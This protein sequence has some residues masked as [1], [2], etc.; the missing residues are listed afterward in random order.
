MITLEKQFVSG[1]GGYSSSPLTYEQLFRTDKVAM[2][3][4]SLNGNVRDYEVFKI[5]V[6]PKGHKVF[7]QIFEDDTEQYPGTSQFGR[8]AWSFENEG[9]AKIRYNDL[10]NE[11]DANVGVVPTRGRKARIRRDVQFP[12]SATWTMKD[13]LAL[14][15]DYKQPC[16]Y[17]YLLKQITAGKVKVAGKVNR[18][19]G[20]GK[21]PLLY[22]VV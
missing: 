8:I 4:R 6:L 13:I 3:K 1:A 19:N 22:S 17:Q 20:R 14:N 18:E 10:V 9:A 2:Y 7:K 12:N 5:V 21:A 15:S 16:M 11:V